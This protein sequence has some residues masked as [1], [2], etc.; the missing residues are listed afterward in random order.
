M[1]DAL[2]VHLGHNQVLELKQVVLIKYAQKGKYL[3][4]N[5]QLHKLKVANNLKILKNNKINNIMA[6]I[7]QI[8]K[9]I[10]Q[11]TVQ[12]KVNLR[13]TYKLL[14][15]KFQILIKATQI[16]KFSTKM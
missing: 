13:L 2:N 3:L 16:L 5:L 11:I 15:I 9:L 10:Q 4:R 12:M 1:M 8:Y 7:G 6:E 14:S